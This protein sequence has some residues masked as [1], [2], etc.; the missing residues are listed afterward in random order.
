VKLDP[1]ESAAFAVYQ[2]K[3]AYALLLGSG[4]SR[5]A[6]I[7]TGWDIVLDLIRRLAEIKGEEAEPDPETWYREVSGEPAAYNVLVEALARTQDER[8]SLLRAFIEPSPEDR[9]DNRKAPQLAHRAISRLVAAGFVRIIV[10]TNFDPLIEHAL[11]EAG[12]VPDVLSTPDQIRGARPFHQAKC[13]VLKVNGDYT[14][15][16]IRNTEAELAAY[17]DEINLYLDRVF[18]EFGLIVCGWSADYDV[19]L[20]DALLRA[21]SR[22]YTTYWT[23]RGGHLRESARRLV[24]HRRAEV[25]TIDDADRFFAQLADKVESLESLSV[26][27]P[28]SVAAAVAMT[29]RSLERRSLIQ[30][31]D[32]VT[33]EVEDVRRTLMGADFPVTI[34]QG[35]TFGQV[36]QTQLSAYNAVI[37]RLLNILA[38]I[39]YFDEGEMSNLI[40]GVI[41]RLVPRDR[42][43]RTR[44]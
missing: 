9:E 25:I 1:L 15:L 3:G 21:P 2:N 12:V 42:D 41:E 38:T 23:A 40:S 6:G 16:R 8:S 18:D 11:E 20:R 35:E 13:V 24:E 43:R 27:H 10:T 31:H 28:V 36:W 5:S 39:A 19:A 33:N 37:E 44:F 4:T 22:R 26:A 7:P 30:T 34:S 29:K 32:L 14:D 17:E